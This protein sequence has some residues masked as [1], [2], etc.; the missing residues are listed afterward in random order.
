M[1]EQPGWTETD[2]KST[3]IATATRAAESGKYHIVYGVDASMVGAAE[4][5]LLQIKDGTDVVWTGHVHQSRDK[6]FPGGITI[7]KGNACSAVL[8]AGAGASDVNLHGKTR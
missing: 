8:A 3:A 1:A 6:T 2:V 5:L 4:I 7:T